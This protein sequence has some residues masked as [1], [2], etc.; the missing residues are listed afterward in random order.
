MTGHQLRQ[1]YLDFFKDHNSLVVPSSSLVPTDPTTLLTS[2]GMQPLVPYFKGEETPPHTRL[3]SCQ[4][5]CRADDIEQVGVTWRHASF[6]EMLGNFSF[7]DYFKR[8]AIIWGWD[9]LTKTLNID[10]KLLYVSVYVDDEEAP[11]IWKNDVGLSDDRIL[12]MGKK[13]NW[14]GPVGKTGPCGPDS[15]IFL[16]RG[17][18]YNTGDPELDRPGGDGDRYGELWN[19]VFQQYNQ[20]EDGSLPLLPAPGIDTGMGLERTAAVL[21]NV[22]T[23]HHTDLF[24][25]LINAI[26]DLSRGRNIE[27]S[28]SPLELNTQDAT[29]KP[30]KIIADHVRAAIFMAS[31][32]IVPGNNGRDYMMK[33]FIRRAFLTARQLDLREPFLHKLVPIVS[34]GFGDVYPEIR[35]REIAIAALIKRE[36]EAFGKTIGSG[37]NRLE[38]L[39]DDAKK[40]GLRVLDGEEV[41]RLY[42]TYGFPPELTQEVAQESGLE[43][44]EAGFKSAQERHSKIS[45]AAVGEYETRTF[46]NLDTEFVG[47]DE[48]KVGARIIA[49]RDT[50]GNSI[51]DDFDGTAQVVLD[52]TSFYAES[53]GQVG[54]IGRLWFKGF[55]AR[56]LDVQ[57]QGKAYVHIIEPVMGFLE[58]G[59]LVFAEVDVERRR[60]VERA[61]SSTH[62]LHAALRNRLGNHV[63]QR[64]S[65]VSP[66]KLRFDFVHFAAISPDE[67]RQIE[68]DV[69]N[70]ILQS[71]AIETREMPIVEARG[72]GAMALFG[73]KYGDVVR[74]VRMGDYSMELCGGTHLS[75]TSSAGFLRILGESGVG[76]NLRRIEALTGNAAL[77]YD[78]KQN[79][80]VLE[81][82]QALNA[83]PQNVVNAAEKMRLRVRELEKQLNEAQ[84]KLA[85]SSLDEIL[86]QAVEIGD[87]TLISARA[88]SGLDANTLRDVIEKLADKL[89]ASGAGDFVLTL[90]S[91]ADGK[92]VW[93]VKAGKSAVAK[94]AHAGN[95][96]R[97]LAK[98]TGGGGGGKPDFA[99]AGGKDSAKIDE[100][101]AMAKDVLAA[102]L[103]V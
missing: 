29:T 70:Q 42:E 73:E 10:P 55:E 72:L 80:R 96:I 38:D 103:K 85:L 102:Q 66:D 90:A 26:S 76:A 83:Q 61:H 52:K 62:L 50:E 49:A 58:E 21:Q 88:P 11:Q 77:E 33:R 54:D 25:P 6:F 16:D 1:Q 18:K 87:T 51:A 98:I 93:A 44:D 8:E 15:E 78:R 32:G 34:Q 23:I 71:V 7:G 30:L 81:V 9:F 36:E 12:R 84:S 20:Q 48:T 13:D 101:L 99:Q 86:A 19:L 57:K 100:A 47:Y 95:L 27:Y 43:I 4:K 3:A 63:E 82:A 56:V 91:E 17:A 45:G 28:I 92:V 79:H 75:N 37:M 67:L 60:A 35:E 69:N 39:L 97:E 59:M 41:F 89:S 2:A 14:W 68:D 31:D 94:G 46:G 5:C 40:K 64:G 74:T 53:G 22:D 24:A 65:L